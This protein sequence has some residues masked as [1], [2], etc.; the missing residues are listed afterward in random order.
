[1]LLEGIFL[2]VLTPFYPDGRLYLR[3]LEH[4]V[5]RYANTSAAGML[6][7]GSAAE[8]DGLT[9]DETREVL[10]TA[11][12]VA[13][14]EQ[15]MLATLGRESVFATLRLAEA[16]AHL[17]YDAVAIRPP[18]F[19]SDASMQLELLTYFQA[20]ADR[21]PLPIVLAS[22]PAR[23]LTVELVAELASH[24]QVLGLLDSDASTARV[25]ALKARTAAV[26]REVNVTPVFAAVTSRMQ[27]QT[28]STTTS[29]NF[30]SAESLG[31]G[32][33]LA[34]APPVSAPKLALKMRPK[35]VGF[36]VLAASTAHMLEGWQAGATGAAPRL[37]ACAPQA[38]CE[39]FQAFRDQDL[40][41]AEEKQRRIETIG[42]R[43]EG[44]SGIAALKHACDLNGYFGGRPRL[45]LLA[46]LAEERA[47]VEKL[48]V[49][50]Q[51]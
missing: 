21:C 17:G 39:V 19:S 7:L 22:E 24:A 46:L 16:A 23:T 20:V 31:A 47:Q 13:A 14:N 4:N 38:C 27:H 12:G 3:K 50:L 49:G 8:A 30:V 34:T 2:P 18:A 37:G 28:E 11:I 33:A 5:A 32:I 43:M 29:G 42:E 41:L 48:L 26:K 25:A 45:P 15:V 51:N 36:Q 1:M 9:D 6:L 10:S 35:K 40:P 44:W